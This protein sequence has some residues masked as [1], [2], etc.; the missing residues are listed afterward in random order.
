MPKRI[1]ITP[2]LSVEDLEQRYRQA[3]HPVERSHYQII[4]LLAKGQRTEAVVEVTGIVEIGF[5]GWFAATTD[6][7]QKR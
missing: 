7:A 4:W 1:S 6:W 5:I 3:N 2:H